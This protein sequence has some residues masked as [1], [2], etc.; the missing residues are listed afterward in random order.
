V[1]ELASPTGQPP[2]V[3]AVVLPAEIDVT[4]AAAVET[5]LTSAAAPGR[6]VLADMSLTTYCDTSGIRAIM[7]A[8]GHAHEI[9]GLLCAAVPSVAVRRVLDLVGASTLFDVHPTVAAAWAACGDSTGQQRH[10]Q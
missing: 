5:K 8:C 1:P 9:G 4:N 7:L 2:E 3:V 10:D 6:T